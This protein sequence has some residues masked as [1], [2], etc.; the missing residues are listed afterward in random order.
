MGKVKSIL[1]RKEV[2]IILIIIAVSL[3]YTM[4]F[5]P[6]PWIR[7]DVNKIRATGDASVLSIETPDEISGTGEKFLVKI[8]LDTKNN[9]VNAVQSYLEFDP[10]IL[11]VIKTDTTDSF[12]KFYPENNFNNQKGLV[13]LSCGSPY[14]GFSGTN[15]LE[16]IEFMP[17]AMQTTS[18]RLTPESMV[19]A[20]DGKGTNLLK[21]FD[22]KTITIK[23]GL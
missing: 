18:I 11:V 3:I 19:L 22:S 7:L 5:K 4:F 13:K 6:S 9:F 10:N 16:I 2:I 15:T 20:N 8:N 14:P 21:N 12:C 1:R 17:K 23:A